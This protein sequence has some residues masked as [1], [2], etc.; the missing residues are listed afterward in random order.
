MTGEASWT[1]PKQHIQRQRREPDS[2]GMKQLSACFLVALMLLAGCLGATETAPESVG[3]TTN[4]YALQTN[5]IGHPET[6]EVGNQAVYVLGVQQE[7]LG[8]WSV[9]PAVLMADFTP[10]EGL[11]GEKTDIGYTLKFTPTVVDQHIE[12][13]TVKKTGET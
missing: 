2:M 7:G 10:V 5:L 4:T 3:E 9:E 12:S 1:S 13:L 11:V 6:I 8:T